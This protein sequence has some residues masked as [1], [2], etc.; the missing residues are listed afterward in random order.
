MKDISALH[1]HSPANF[2]AAMREILRN[3]VSWPVY[4]TMRDITLEYPPRNV[5]SEMAEWQPPM[6]FQQY[7][8]PEFPVN[9]FC[10]PLRKF[11]V[12]L[13]AETQTPVDLAGN[14][15]VS[16]LSA[17]TQGKFVV[18]A[19]YNWQVHLS[20]YT[21]TVLPSGSGKTPVHERANKPVFDFESELRE[22]MRDE[23]VA[24]Q[25]EKRLL[26]KELE[27][28]ER[29]AAKADDTVQYGEWREKAKEAAKKLAEL[30]VLYNPQLIAD[31]VTAEA[32]A[33]ILYEQNEKLYACASEGDL[34]SILG[35]RY[36]DGKPNFKIWLSGYDGSPII[37]NRKTSGMIRLE[38]PLISLGL[39][40]QPGVL[41]DLRKTPQF[42]EQGLIPRLWLAMP[43]SQ[44]GYRQNN[45]PIMAGEIYA[46]YAK[47]INNLLRIQ[48]R[49][50]GKKNNPYQL[51]LSPEA[52]EAYE[53]YFLLNEEEVR[54][55]GFQENMLAWAGKFGGSIMKTAGLLHLS[56]FYDVVSPEQYEIGANVMHRAGELRNYYKYHAKAAYGVMKD[57]PR[58]SDAKYLISRILD[59]QA[60]KFSQRDLFEKVKGR[61]GTVKKMRPVIELLIEHNYIREVKSLRTA[62]AG[63]K[64]QVFEVNPE[65]LKTPSHNSHKS[66][67]ANTANEGGEE[68][69]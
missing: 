10:E 45:P 59:M 41:K 14:S 54:E 8:L 65:A 4:E 38:R 35:G 21:A 2:K 36:G 50:D 26:E 18:R 1:Q 64:T 51:H 57:D 58:I 46:N 6:P 43:Q 67:Y 53:A 23:V 60:P 28:A 52:K 56:D 16:V 61:F 25:S 34:F 7:D 31:D 29:R 27:H 55:G 69:A 12:D 13:A 47:V 39:T 48:E 15:V 22:I 32:L 42:E 9:V 3:T 37:I 19:T 20:S 44:V 62:K 49:K 63:R 24:S 66:T 33:Q 30:D 5:A 40:F 68:I 17:A 11:V